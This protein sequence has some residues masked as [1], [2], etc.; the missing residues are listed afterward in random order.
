M[1]RDPRGDI[2][3]MSAPRMTTTPPTLD[4]GFATTGVVA[5]KLSRKSH[6]KSRNGCQNCKQRKIKVSD[7]STAKDIMKRGLTSG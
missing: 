6:R 5:R 7:S 4:N 1:D 2:P 3:I